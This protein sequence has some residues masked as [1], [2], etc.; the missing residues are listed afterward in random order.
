M[1]S[2]TAKRRALPLAVVVALGVF[3]AGDLL[4]F[5]WHRASL[6]YALMLAGVFGVLPTAVG[7]ALGTAPGTMDDSRS[8]KR[9]R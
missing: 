6:G 2:G 9:A 4:L 3:C 7:A 1:S 5:H 8:S